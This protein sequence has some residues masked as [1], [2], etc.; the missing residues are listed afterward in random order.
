MILHVRPLVLVQPGVVIRL[1]Q[2]PDDQQDGPK[3]AD[4]HEAF[5]QSGQERGHHARHLGTQRSKVVE[6]PEEREHVGVRPGGM[7]KPVPDLGATG[8]TFVPHLQEMTDKQQ[9]RELV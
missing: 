4:A 7:R 9:K 5:A 6:F 8:E 2:A 3:D 1:D